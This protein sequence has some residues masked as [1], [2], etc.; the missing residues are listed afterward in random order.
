MSDK[1]KGFFAFSSVSMFCIIIEAVFWI[2]R[3]YAVCVKVS[4]ARRKLALIPAPR[5]IPP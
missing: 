2:I 4:L 3:P 1:V 5:R